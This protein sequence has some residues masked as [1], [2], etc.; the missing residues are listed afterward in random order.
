MRNGRTSRLGGPTYVTERAGLPFA[1]LGAITDLGTGS[2]WSGAEIRRAAWARRQELS[3]LGVRHGA[4]VVIAHDEAG[5]FFADLFAI[6]SLGA[7]A[8]VVNSQLTP[9]EFSNVV[10]FAEAA[11]V[12][13]GET[14]RR[15]PPPAGVAVVP[16][17]SLPPAGPDSMSIPI[18]AP[19]SPGTDR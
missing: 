17:A 8:A 14:T 19:G 2:E 7:C 3:D 1:A 5:P 11:A 10:G 9:D 15:F 13:V 4:C 16:A 12:I 18:D 6:W